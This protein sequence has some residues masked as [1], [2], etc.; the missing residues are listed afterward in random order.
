[1]PGSADLDHGP[2]EPGLRSHG[3]E[4]GPGLRKGTKAATAAQMFARDSGATMAQVMEKT[5][6]KSVYNLLRKLTE[7]GHKLK[8]EDG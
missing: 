7:A 5:G 2:L 4:N 1:L 6:G 8:R 3:A